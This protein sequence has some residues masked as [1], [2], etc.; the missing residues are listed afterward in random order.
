MENEELKF[1]KFGK[2]TKM[3]IKKKE[4]KWDVCLLLQFMV[5][6]DTRSTLSKQTK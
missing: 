4:E 6:L 2:Y 3:K 1:K 5:P